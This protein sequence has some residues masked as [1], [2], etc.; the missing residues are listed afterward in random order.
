M[1]H[2]LKQQKVW[3]WIVINIA[4]LMVGGST[5]GLELPAPRLRISTLA[6]L[7]AVAGLLQIIVL[8]FYFGVNKKQAIQWLAISTLGWGIGCGVIGTIIATLTQIG[9]TFVTVDFE[10]LTGSSF[11]WLAILIGGL[12]V[13]LL[14]ARI[15][16]PGERKYPRWEVHSAIG[17]VFA[18][19]TGSI[20]IR[21]V[22]G[23]DI[24]KYA[25][26]GG[27]AG[28][29]VGAISG[30][31][32][33]KNDTLDESNLKPRQKAVKHKVVQIFIRVILGTLLL[34]GLVGFVYDVIRTF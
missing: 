31:V 15:L 30:W 13:S 23:G 19:I 7:G 29:I 8:Y 27:V 5:I 2:Y 28:T 17:W 3:L 12:S 34:L 32:L 24:L 25:L 33:V 20:I 4:A 16:Y 26:S 9:Y 10:V 14:Q 1:S 21:F 11:H 18:V 6:F 22:P